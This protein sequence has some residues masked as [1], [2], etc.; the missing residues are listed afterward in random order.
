MRTSG[1]ESAVTFAGKVDDDLL[2]Q[3][4]A[5]CDIFA[6]PNRNDH[7]D[8]EG[9]GIVFMEAAASCRPTIG[10]NTGGVPEAVK[11]GETGLLVSGTDSAELVEVVR[12]LAGSPELRARLGAAG[13]KRV[14]REFTWDHAA[15]RLAELHRASQYIKGSK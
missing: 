14:L 12:R 10:G 2:P 4:Y 15:A 6:L 9:F 3:L 7:G 8:I 1:L 11:E 5:A 13:R